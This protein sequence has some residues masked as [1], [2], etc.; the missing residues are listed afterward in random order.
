MAENDEQITKEK[1]SVVLSG[2]TDLLLDGQTHIGLAVVVSSGTGQSTLMI[3]DVTGVKTGQP[4]Y[5]TKPIG[6]VGKNLADFLNAKDVTLPKQVE[7][8]LG[9]A[10]LSCNA[11]YYSKDAM[12]MMFALEFKKG[13]I[14]SLISEEGKPDESFEKL[15]DI[16]G[17]AVRVIK[18]PNKDSFE[19]LKDYAAGLSAESASSGS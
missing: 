19:V 8:L 14:T 13:L 7:S 12:L 9:N 6:L 2:V 10:T 5:I 3:P 17:A 1:E 18:C 16:K 15:F 4:V 11:F